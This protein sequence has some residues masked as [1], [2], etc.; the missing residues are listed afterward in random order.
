[1]E[2]RVDDRHPAS[3]PYADP[4]LAVPREPGPKVWYN[5]RKT[6]CHRLNGGGLYGTT[7]NQSTV[8]IQA[9]FSQAGRG[10]PAVRV[11][12]GASANGDRNTYQHPHAPNTNPEATGNA[13]PHGDAHPHAAA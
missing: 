4:V 6:P 12:Y 8:G 9:Q 3:L 1:M 10:S 2:I 11:P 13:D 7:S 5:R